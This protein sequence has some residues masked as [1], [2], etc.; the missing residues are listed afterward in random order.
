MDIAETGSYHKLHR[1]GGLNAESLSDAWEKIVKENNKATGSNRFSNYLV[2]AKVYGALV[3][4]Y[5]MVRSAL[6]YLSFKVDHEMIDLLIKKGYNISTQSSRMYAESLTAALKRVENVGT[7]ATIKQNELKKL[8]GDKKESTGFEQIMAMLSLQLG[9]TVQDDITL[10]R[11]N[12]YQKLIKQK[13]GI[14]TK[15]R[16]KK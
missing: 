6:I 7:Q 5:L 14:N 8:T 13:D 12:E 15:Q 3:A 4:D 16:N 10:A 9:F 1:S 11:F 2:N